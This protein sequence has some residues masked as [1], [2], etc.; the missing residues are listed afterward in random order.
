[1]EA[2]LRLEEY[3]KLVFKREKLRKD[4]RLFWIEYIREFGDLMEREYSLEIECIKCKKI[5]AF[6]QA[7][8]N[9][10]ATVF[11]AELDSYIETA[12]KNY[13][14]ELEMIVS[15]KNSQTTALPEVDYY[16]LK[17]LYRRLATMLHPDLHPALF[18]HEEIVELWNRISGAYGRNDI[19][20]LQ[21]LEMLAVEA[22]K[23]YE[24]VA[25]QIT[26]ENIEAKIAAIRIEIDDIIHTDPYKYKEL[27]RDDDALAEKK[28]ELQIMISEYEEYLTELKAEEQKIMKDV[29]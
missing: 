21:A 1:M 12:M 14:E 26:V 5:I 11:R 6:C 28:A 16:K 22:I 15:V 2:D 29:V 3:K 27:L 9:H 18:E 13:Y 4:A 8:L 20:E 19:E 17:R 7:R 24:S 10:G 23:K 25:Q